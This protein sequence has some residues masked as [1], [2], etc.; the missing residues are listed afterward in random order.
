MG[1]R[2]NGKWEI[3]E[4]GNLEGGRSGKWETGNP[5]GK[6]IT[7]LFMLLARHVIKHLQAF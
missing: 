4:T 6:N 7:I 3:G 1:N 5:F 2:G